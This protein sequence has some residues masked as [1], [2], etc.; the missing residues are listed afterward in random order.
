MTGWSANTANTENIDN[1][2]STEKD[3]SSTQTPDI[4]IEKI[5]NL[6]REQ[7]KIVSVRKTGESTVRQSTRQC[8]C[9]YTG[10]EY[11]CGY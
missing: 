9:L 2:N 5:E 3:D 1:E 11:A 10:T 7:K 4:L 8:I 6:E